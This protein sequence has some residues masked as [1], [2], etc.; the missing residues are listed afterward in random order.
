MKINLVMNLFVQHQHIFY[1]L[2]PEIVVL[3]MNVSRLILV[4]DTSILF[5]SRASISG[6]RKYFGFSYSWCGKKINEPKMTR[7]KSCGA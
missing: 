1:S 6:R 2:R 4:I 7:I 5:T 3:E